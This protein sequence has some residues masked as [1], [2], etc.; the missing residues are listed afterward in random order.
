MLGLNELSNQRQSEILASTIFKHLVLL[1]LPCLISQC[2]FGTRLAHTSLAIHQGRPWYLSPVLFFNSSIASTTETR[3]NTRPP[4][5]SPPA[6]T[7]FNT[8]TAT[9]I[10]RCFVDSSVCSVGLLGGHRLENTSLAIRQV[11]VWALSLL[12]PSSSTT[13]SNRTEFGSLAPLLFKLTKQNC[14]LNRIDYRN[15]HENSL[16]QNSTRD[17]SSSSFSS[18][19]L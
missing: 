14:L 15:Q 3:F 5:P 19:F 11:R 2:L 8:K 6:A 18:S 12:F 16:G 17:L 13:Q 9:S 10:E 4:L 1:A 7:E